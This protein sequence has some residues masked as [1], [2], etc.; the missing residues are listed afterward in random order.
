M[1]L[2]AKL[3]KWSY[4]RNLSGMNF[5]KGGVSSAGRWNFLD[6]GLFSLSKGCLLIKSS[7]LC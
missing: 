5:L 3:I 7:V 4:I 6:G 2:P 1:K